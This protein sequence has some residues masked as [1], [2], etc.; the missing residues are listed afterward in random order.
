MN[1]LF[2]DSFYYIALL[3]KSDAA[4]SKAVD[5]ARSHNLAIV[6]TEWV[7]VEVADALNDRRV[8]ASVVTLI[9]TLRSQPAATIIPA[10]PELFDA[11]FDL[12]AHRPDKDWSLTDCTSFVVMRDHN[13]TDALTADHHFEQAGFTPLLLT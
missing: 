4:H 5:I 7:L 3:N 8:R 11:A 6:T 2:A 12:Y 9:R 13:L 10:T 1:V